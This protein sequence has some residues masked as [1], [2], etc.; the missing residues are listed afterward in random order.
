MPGLVALIAPRFSTEIAQYIPA[1]SRSLV[2]HPGVVEDVLQDPSFSLIAAHVHVPGT[3]GAP[4]PIT[5]EDNT[6]LILMDGELY[7]AERLR[8]QL[9]EAGHVLRTSEDAEVLLHA[10]EEYGFA[11][12]SQLNGLFLA[13]IHDRRR[14]QT[15]I[16]NDLLGLYRAFY[17]EHGEVV[18]LA[19][20]LKAIL[21]CRHGSYSLDHRSIYER[22]AIGGILDDRTQV[23]E[24]RRLPAASWWVYKDGTLHKRQYG[25]LDRL[26]RQPRMPDPEF[27]RCATELFTRI[28]PRYVRGNGVGLALTGGWDTRSIFATLTKLE[29]HMPCFTWT[30]PY[31]DSLDVKVARKIARTWGQDLQVLR[32]GRDFLENYPA[33]A[34]ELVDL[35]DGSAELGA[36]HEVYLNRGVRDRAPIKLCGKFG[37]QFM[38]FRLPMGRRPVDRQIFDPEFLGDVSDPPLPPSWDGDLL[39]MAQGVRWL[40]PTGFSAAEN[41]QLLVRTPFI[42]REMI[43]LICQASPSA[44]RGAQTQKAIIQANCPPLALLPSDKGEFI[45]TGR[46]WHDARLM[47]AGRWNRMWTMA[48]KAYLLRDLPHRCARLDPIVTWLGIP[49]LILGRQTIG[50]WRHWLNHEFRSFAIGVLQDERTLSREYLNGPFV[51]RMLADHF[52]HRANYTLEIGRLLMVELWCRQFMDTQNKMKEADLAGAGRTI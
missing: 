28:M 50:A 24:I 41:S 17:S 12:T 3:G 35:T 26:I 18:A 8:A 25:N 29:I 51:R 39:A 11:C 1:M 2:H 19:S 14:K 36:S 33:M 6:C 13:I 48:E 20:E 45:R 22:L 4:Q 7:G 27:H 40:W 21:A 32:L 10:Y 37:T 42:D 30:G 15:V 23:R 52:S 5:N 34:E 9:C 46:R 38:S 44:L 31:R 47:M 43:E 16:V 49:W